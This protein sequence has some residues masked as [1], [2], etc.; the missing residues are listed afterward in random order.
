M[1]IQWTQIPKLNALH[2]YGPSTQNTAGI[3][4]DSRDVKKNFAFFCIIGVETD[5]HL[6]IE[7]A[8]Q[9][10]ATTIIASKQSIIKS[11]TLLHTN[12]SFVV[13]HDSREALA[14]TAIE[15]NHQASDKIFKVGVTGTNGKTTVCTY[16]Q[17]LFNLLGLP[18][19]MLGTN[20]IFSSKE[21]LHIK[22]STPTTPMSSD[23]Q[24]TFS[25]LVKLG[26]KAVSMEVSSIALDQ[27]RVCG[28]KF[29]V[30]I[31]T[32]I[33]QEHMEYHKTFNH[34][35]MSKLRLFSQTKASVVNLDDD[36]M[37]KDIL[38]IVQGSSFLTYSQNE[39]S[40]ADLIWTNLYHNDE[41]ISFDLL[42]KGISQRISVPIYGEHNVANLVAAIGAALLANVPLEEIL[43]VLP[44][45]KQVD[46]RFQVIHG[47]EKRKIILDYAHTPVA[48]DSIIRAVK[49]LTH[50]RL[51]VL[52]TGVGI[53]DSAKMPKMAKVAEGKADI[54]VVSVDHPG[55]KDPW[56]IVDDV[57]KGFS[58]PYLQEVL[59][60]PMRHE[61]VKIAL[62][63]SQPGDIILLTGGNINGSQLV[64]GKYIPHSDENII[65]DYF[66]NSKL[67]V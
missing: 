58:V 24:S 55:Y 67:R 34:Y 19:G 33:S 8:I 60:S 6:Y 44:D 5:G 31:H 12:V 65:K 17:N 46:G 20:G 13:V 52:I 36:G 59:T 22:K 14:Y 32:N 37:S 66:N 1:D 64:Q 57:L 16:V 38:Q 28:F 21:M 41:G 23:I 2:V 42:Y 25:E 51:V 54:L 15:Y 45:I 29:D 27:F 61:A 4:Y 26:D 10:G 53:R 7:E 50:N 56:N 40:R 62:E 43:V 9:N 11:F 35:K 18:C 63:A 47:P 3:V 30:A 49:T 48:L 39:S